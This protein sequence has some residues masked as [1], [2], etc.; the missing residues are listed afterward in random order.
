MEEVSKKH[1]KEM[2]DV[3][4]KHSQELQKVSAA[5]EEVSSGHIRLFTFANFILTY[6]FCIRYF[7]IILIL[8]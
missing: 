5:M 6:F 3:S 1:A 2:E 4:V 7:N 8:T